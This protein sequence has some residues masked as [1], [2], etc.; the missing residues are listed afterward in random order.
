M[1]GGQCISAT[2]IY[3]S[4][5]ILKSG[6]AGRTASSGPGTICMCVHIVC[7][8]FM[9][10]MCMYLLLWLIL[11][12]YSSNTALSGYRATCAKYA[13]MLLTNMLEQADAMF[14]TDPFLFAIIYSRNKWCDAILIETLVAVLLRFVATVLQGNSEPYD[15]RIHCSAGTFGIPVLWLREAM[16]HVISF[17]Y[18]SYMIVW[19]RPTV[20]PSSRV[21][22]FRLYVT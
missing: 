10:I 2:Q 19:M 17:N 16:H 12:G 3:N 8:I 11:T 14:I 7:V 6:Q 1:H 22:G 4:K 9:S 21:W 5:I 18:V 15:I 20:Q 13:V